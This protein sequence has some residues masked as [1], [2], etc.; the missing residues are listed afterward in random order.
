MGVLVDNVEM[1][2]EYFGGEWWHV[3]HVSRGGNAAVHT[4]IAWPCEGPHDDTGPMAALIAAAT[5]GE[6]AFADALGDMATQTDGPFGGVVPATWWAG[7]TSMRKAAV[8]A[9]GVAWANA[10]KCP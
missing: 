3:I 10:G 1:V 9:Q 2:S 7:L 8:V 5:D 4:G 6:T